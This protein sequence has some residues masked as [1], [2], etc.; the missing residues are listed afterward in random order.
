VPHLRLA[1]GDG[2][3][4]VFALRADRVVLGR[5]HDCDLILPDVLL[6]RR[7]AEILRSAGGW[8]LRD[9]GSLNGTRLNGVLVEGEQPL[10]DGDRISVSDWT[11]VF[12]D[13]D[14][15]SDPSLPTAGER[16]RDVTELATRSDI[17][18]GALARQ[19]RILGVLTRAAAAVV[20]TPSA[21]SLLDTL[22]GH[23]LEA[24]PAR[25]GAVVLFEATPT[26]AA[27]RAVE[28]PPPSGIDPAVAERLLR[29]RGPFLAPRVAAEQGRVRS[30]LCAPLWFSGAP[31]APERI[32]GC[33][34]LEAPADPS[35][36]EAEH[37]HLVTAVANLAASRLESLRLREENA[38]KRRLEEDLRGAARIQQSLLPEE[39]P[40]L[41]GWELAGSSRL[42]SAVGA[43]YYD[44]SP[45][46]GGLL[47]ALGDVAGKGLAAALL[48]ASL[49]AA[50]RARW[51]EGE[52]LSRVL[53]QVNEILLQTVPPNRFAT[54]FLARTDTGTGEM[55]WV[56]AGHAAP[57]VARADGRHEVLEATGTI[58]GVFAGA[59][60]EERRT[61]LGPGDVLVLLSDGVV[62]AARQAEGDLGPGRLAA[63]VRAS[64]GSASVQLAALQAAAEDGLGGARR[65][66]DH[67]FVVLRRTDHS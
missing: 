56:N 25:R 40:P 13:A 23:L 12:H 33:V 17:E 15:P 20:A 8:S 9:L 63:I 58:L 41:P 4:E 60:W 49:R 52:P 30:V 3:S 67:T 16:L 29:S 18:A 53:T 48:M 66:D 65:A 32:A 57:L 44:F 46:D 62:E 10:R 37:L 19:S 11:L 45:D 59:S 7:H 42:C 55:L 28:G 61:R 21:E 31:P 47:L 34:A 14:T 1:S 36:F 6:S 26:V 24:V 35:P 5:S 64:G 38:D 27:A 51:R 22:L 39:T 50:V 54:L 2:P 43:D